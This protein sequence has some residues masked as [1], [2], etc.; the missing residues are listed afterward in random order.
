MKQNIP[1]QRVD[2][3]E[4]KKRKRTNRFLNI[5]IAV[6]A[7]LILLFAYKLFIDRA[8]GDTPE[9]TAT[10][11]EQ[12]ANNEENTSQ[13]NNANANEGETNEG[14]GDEEVNDGKVIVP[15]DEAGVI[16]AFTN[17]S[18]GPVGT[19]QS[20][21]HTT[22][23]DSSSQDWK[24]MLKAVTLATGVEESNMII[25]RIGNGGSPSTAIANISTSDQQYRYRVH[26][27]WVENEGWQPTLVKQIET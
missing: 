19:E 24:E 14:S 13:E 25:W 18:W 27:E 8:T 12:P 15:T 23:F 22:Q 10:Q 3:L 1:N 11:G 26:I 6:V 4:T 21:P 7:L 17:P 16:E 20:E 2:R 9:D 5:A